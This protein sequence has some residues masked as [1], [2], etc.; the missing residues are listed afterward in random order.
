MSYPSSAGLT[1]KSFR[2]ARAGA[3]IGVKPYF[4]WSLHYETEVP[5]FPDLPDCPS[6]IP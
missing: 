4:K 5:S 2:S 6:G 3:L 1:D